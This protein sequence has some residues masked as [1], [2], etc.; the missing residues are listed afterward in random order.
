MHELS[1]VE[2]VLQRVLTIADEHGGLPVSCVKLSIGAL[3]QVDPDLLAFAFQAAVAGTLA[4][5]A[6]LEWRVTPARV[7]CPS[8]G[9]C[10][11][12]DDLFWACPACAA[13]G[14]RVLA[15]DELVLDAVELEEAEQPREEP[16]WK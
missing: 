10:F 12:P 4:E 15:G 1:I 7:A 5:R 11:Q 16:S 3:Q 2:N 9:T 13:A 14:G 6:A 8:C